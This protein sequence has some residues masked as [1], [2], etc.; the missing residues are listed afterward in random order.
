M[1]VSIT[2]AQNIVLA[3]RAKEHT[4]ELQREEQ[5]QQRNEQFVSSLKSAAQEYCQEVLNEA[6]KQA[7]EN[8]RTFLWDWSAGYPANLATWLAEKFDLEV[9][10]EGWYSEGKVMWMLPHH[11]RYFDT[12]EQHPWKD[13]WSKYGFDKIDGWDDWTRRPGDLDHIVLAFGNALTEV[14][15]EAGYKASNTMSIDIKE[16]CKQKQKIYGR[17]EVSWATGKLAEAS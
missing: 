5:R 16:G 2:E 4:K 6:I 7:S 3:A 9:G 10:V 15:V 8:G 1:V 12:P 14:L 11:V 13:A 17:V